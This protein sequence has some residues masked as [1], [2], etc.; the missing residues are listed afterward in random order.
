MFEP[1]E[2]PGYEKMLNEATE[3]VASW[4]RNNDWYSS[5]GGTRPMK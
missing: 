4:V 5:A 1:R 3:M 2:N